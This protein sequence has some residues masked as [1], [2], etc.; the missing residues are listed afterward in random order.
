MKCEVGVDGVGL[1]SIAGPI[2]IC[3]V[4][5]PPHCDLDVVVRDSKKMTHNQH[6]VSSVAIRAAALHYAIAISNHDTIERYGMRR[7]ETECIRDS[8]QAVRRVLAED[9]GIE[10]AKVIIDGI[11]S[12]SLPDV[13]CHVKADADYAVV[14]AASIIAKAHRDDLMRKMALKYPR[15]GFDENY[16]YA[17]YDHLRALK[18]YGPCAIHRRSTAPVKNALAGT[19]MYWGHKLV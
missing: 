10:R 2:A 5:L 3:C 1:G 19:A 13:E 11:V 12:P 9:Y 16:G 15:Y 18:R 8:I 4:A 14:S 17:T 7:C 6:A